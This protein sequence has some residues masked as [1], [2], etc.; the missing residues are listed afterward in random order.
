MLQASVQ[1]QVIPGG[2]HAVE[3]NDGNVEEAKRILI[4]EAEN[5]AK[6]LENS[7]TVELKDVV[8]K[9]QVCLVVIC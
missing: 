1:A 7:P 5:T 2:E 8:V 9:K 4:Q 3:E 6:T